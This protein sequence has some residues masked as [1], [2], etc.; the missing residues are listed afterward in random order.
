MQNTWSYDEIEH[1]SQNPERTYIKGSGKE[2][3]AQWRP[4]SAKTKTGDARNQSLLVVFQFWRETTGSYTTGW[5]GKLGL[6][7]INLSL[8]K[9]IIADH[10][11]SSLLKEGWTMIIQFCA[12]M[13]FNSWYKIE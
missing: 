13:I 3:W 11:E 1:K 6:N 5:S 10:E 12:K 4:R 8:C 2:K 9:E 7:T